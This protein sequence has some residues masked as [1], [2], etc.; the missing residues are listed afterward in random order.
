MAGPATPDLAGIVNLVGR[1]TEAIAGAGAT[2]VDVA[3]AAGS[4]VS[5]DGAPLG[6]KASADV[7][8]VEQ[9]SVTRQWGGDVPNAAAITLTPGL[10]LPQLEAQLG[11]ARPIPSVRPGEQ[12][13]VL[14]D[15]DGDAT[16][17]AAVDA[18][19]EVRTITVRR[20]SD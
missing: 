12:L 14:G 17:L 5:D 16:T 18:G 1:L 8:G 10:R 6:V 19:G 3:R 13:V 11:A 20:E 4:D 7:P 9:V 2:A 15:A